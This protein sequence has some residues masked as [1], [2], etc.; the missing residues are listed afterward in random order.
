MARTSSPLQS[1]VSPCGLAAQ[2]DGRGPPVIDLGVRNRS[3][4]PGGQDLKTAASQPG[5][6]LAGGG[7]GDGQ[8]EN[9]AET[10]ANH[11][12]IEADRS[13]DRPPRGPKR[14][15]RRHC[16]ARPRRCPASPR[17]PARPPADSP[18]RRDLPTAAEG[19]RP[20]PRR[21]RFAGR[22]PAWRRPPRSRRTARPPRPGS[23]SR[24]RRASSLRHNSGQ[25][26]TSQCHAGGDRTGQ[27]PRAVDQDELLLFSPLPMVPQAD[28]L[29]DP[30][31]CTLVIMW[32]GSRRKA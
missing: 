5:Q 17:L 3:F 12:G 7:R 4:H 13:A 31:L 22:T 9:R 10:G 29:L 30:G 20:R 32:A 8:R 18:A 28:R 2:D 19:P 25:T 15:P 14:P 23:I 27:F 21:L 11:V 24:S 26:K 16:G 6:H 1:E